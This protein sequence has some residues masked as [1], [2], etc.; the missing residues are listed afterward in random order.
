MRC[1]STTSTPTVAATAQPSARP[2][3]MRVP[4]AR[5]RARARPRP[6]PAIAPIPGCE[7]R[8]VVRVHDALGG[9]E[10]HVLHQ[11]P[12]AEHERA[13]QQ[14][15]APAPTSSAR[16]SSDSPAPCGPAA[17]AAQ[18]PSVPTGANASIQPAWSPRPDTEQPQRARRAPERRSA[19]ACGRRAA[20]Q[21]APRL[22]RGF[23]RVAACRAGLDGAFAAGAGRACVARVARGA[24]RM[25]GRGHLPGAARPGLRRDRSRCIRRSGRARCCS[26]SCPRTGAATPA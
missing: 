12:A 4:T 17:G 19:P 13:R 6:A 5:Q 3:P 25:P 2:T 9:A 22:R 14:R 1:I 20:D 7:R 24:A 21:R 8:D 23:D 26:W 16:R 10:H 18:Q 15:V 11:Q